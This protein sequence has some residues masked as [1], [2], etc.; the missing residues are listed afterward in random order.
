MS[1]FPKFVEFHEEGMREGFQIEPQI[2]PIEERVELIN[3]LSETGLKHI[4]V[5]SFVNPKKVPTMA[6][7]PEMFSRINKKPGVQY[8]GLWLNE[9]G[10]RRALDTP[11]IDLKGDLFFYASEGLARS[12]NNL[13]FDE[14][15]TAQ[16]RW[17]DLYIE[18]NI[19]IDSAGFMCCFGCNIDG[20]IPMS[21]VL[22]LIDFTNQLCKSRG[23]PLPTLLIA[24]T[25]G[26]ANPEQ[27]KQRIGAIREKYPDARLAMHIHDTRG[28]GVANVYAAL[29]MGVDRFD[30]SIAGLGGC[31]FAGHKDHKAAG[32]VCT[33][34]SVFLCHELGIETGIDLGKLIEASQMAEKIIG[35]YLNGKVMHSGSLSHFRA[36]A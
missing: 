36:T 1:D 12:N 31:P 28:L 17:L 33:E 18:N 7:T 10:F 21:R 20:D 11:G 29:E 23:V 22:Q 3:A 34:D 2:Y 25:M 9:S 15:M 26:W 16:E 35:R 8:T 4:Q 24:D 27:V 30:S 13:S 6:D 32:N 19:D 14:M 5:G